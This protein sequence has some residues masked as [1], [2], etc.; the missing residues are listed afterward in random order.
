MK[1]AASVLLCALIFVDSA[2]AE[3]PAGDAERYW[4]QWRG[5][6]ATGVAP[7][8]KPPVEWSETRNVRWKVE[9]PGRGNATPIVWGDRVYV[10][11]AV[12]TDEMVEPKK[13]VERPRGERPRRPERDRTGRDRPGREGPGRDRPG[14][15]GHNWMGS[16]QPTHIYEF[17]ILAL[18]RRTGE[19]V[20]QKAL[21]KKLPHEGGH[22]DGS[23]ASNSP[24]TDGEHL[25]AHFG[26]RGLYGLD[27]YGNVLWQKD[28]GEMQTRMGF[29]EGS[30]PALYGD[31]VVVNWDHEGQSFIVA[32][33]KR[34]GEKLW[35]VDRDEHTSWATPVVVV[36]DGKP[37][38]MTS[39]T[40]LIRSYDLSTGELIWQCGG[41]TM[42][43]IP[44]LV[45]DKGL[46]C[47]MSGFRGN[48][49]VAI[50]LAGAKGD[51]SDSPAVVWRYDKK[52]TPYVPSPL[53]YGGALYFL[54]NNRAILSCLDAKTGKQ[55][56]TKQRLEGL[57]GVFASPVGAADRVYIVG[58]GGKTA[59]VRHDTKFELLATNTLED[60]FSASPAIVDGEIYLRGLK[61]CFK[62]HEF[63]DETNAKDSMEAI[64]WHSNLF[65]IVCGK[66]SIHSCRPRRPSPR[67]V[68][69]ACQTEPA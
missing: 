19:I 24:V 62:T 34:T 30:S 40:G 26:S 10:Q 59:V 42:N 58:R 45:Y 8:G 6:T 64:L 18:D 36:V 54:D 33:D 21:T 66:R 22:K 56:Y 38:V 43:V 61:G 69:R 7:Y 68:G 44:S 47:A 65:P 23:Q 27:M 48:A 5:P 31:T 4:P 49:L 1:R 51:I 39:A 20:W 50:R 28:L 12:K 9:I 17:T 11:T 13:S 37:Q 67:E 53:L 35:K 52:G 57:H 25:I 16:V 29:G 15:R 46:V 55:H 2:H 14:R 60:S 32:L 3:G 63:A 41:M